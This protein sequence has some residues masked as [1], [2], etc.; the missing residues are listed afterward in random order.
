[1]RVQVKAIEATTNHDVKA[2]EYYLKAAFAASA[3]EAV[4][5]V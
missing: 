4:Q 1:V 2:V 5:G 3:G